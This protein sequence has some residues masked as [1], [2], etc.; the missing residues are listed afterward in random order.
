MGQNLCWQVLL[1]CL[2]VWKP[3][4]H[5]FDEFKELLVSNRRWRESLEDWSTARL[6]K[7]SL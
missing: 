5:N 1:I 4:A 6:Y 7:M 3:A 2:Y